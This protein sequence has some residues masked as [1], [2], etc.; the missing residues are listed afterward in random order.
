MGFAALFDPLILTVSN[1]QGVLLRGAALTLQIAAGSFLVGLLLGMTSAAAKLWGG[2]IAQGI[3]GTYTTV[4][5]AVPELLL[6]IILYYA[7]SSGLSAILGMLGFGQ[8]EINGFATAIVVLG[9]VQ[10][11]YAGEV[12]R[13]SI[14]AIPAGQLEAARA[15]AFTPW[16]FL[17]R[18]ILPAML[19][20]ALP[21]LANLWVVLIK[22]TSLISVIGLSELLSSAK[23]A[24]ASTRMYFTFYCVAGL[25]YLVMTLASNFLFQS[26]ERRFRRTQQAI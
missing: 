7:G 5:R 19:P 16:V 8:V 15:F 14:L 20:V 22:E 4:F 9:I 21:G 12:I 3:A 17:R 26:I 2:T 10:G 18:I 25:M 23:T 1:W 6:I 11:A 13:G 24:A